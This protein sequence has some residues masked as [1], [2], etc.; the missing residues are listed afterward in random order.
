MQATT[1]YRTRNLCF[2]TSLLYHYT[3]RL[4]N[5][6]DISSLPVTVRVS[7]TRVLKLPVVVLHRT[8][9]KCTKNPNAREEALF[10]SLNFLFGE[11]LLAVAVVVC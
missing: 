10:Y 2:L 1:L 9:K 3:T 6:L 7:K 11:H 4:C 8:A 5:I